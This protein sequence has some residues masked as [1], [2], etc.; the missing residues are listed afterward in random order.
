MR[1]A[2]DRVEHR[3]PIRQQ[4]RI[5]PPRPP[6]SSAVTITGR[7]EGFSYA[8]ALK[9]AR[10]HINLEALGIKASR[11]R[12]A[13]NGGLLIEVSGENSKAKAEELVSQLRGVLKDSAAVSCPVKKRELRVIGFDESVST[14]EITEALCSLGGCALEDVKIGPIR[15]M[16]NGLGMVWT[17]LPVAAAIKVANEGRVRMGDRKSVV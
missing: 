15:T 6:M 13:L 17:Q 1:T 11:V 14:D 7:A 4:Q 9:N 5:R 12:K 16:A 8:T 10:E 3:P 2:G